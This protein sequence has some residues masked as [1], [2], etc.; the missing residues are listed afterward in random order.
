MRRR[1]SVATQPELERGLHP[2][3]ESVPLQAALAL[4]ASFAILSPNKE[5]A[6]AVQVSPS[7]TV[8]MPGRSAPMPEKPTQ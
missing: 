5:S 2:S 1:G 7:F 3:A 4:R 8:A 6:Y